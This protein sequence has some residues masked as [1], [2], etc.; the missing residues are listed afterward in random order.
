MKSLHKSIKATSYIAG[1][2]AIAA[3]MLLVVFLVMSILG[4]IH[5]RKERITLQTKTITKIYDATPLE[6]SEPIISYG[7]L[8]EGHSIAIR[9]IPEYTIVGV[10]DNAPEFVILDESGAD[11]SAQYDINYDYGKLIIQ[12]RKITLSC[13]K[14]SKVYDGMPITCNEA[15]LSGGS[16]VPGDVIV[17]EGGNT[18]LL[19]GEVK[20]QPAYR[21]V[22]ESGADVTNQYKITENFGNLEIL[23]I[24]LY[25]TT[26]SAEK[27]YD[28]MPLV[29]EEWTITGGS[30]EN[31]QVLKAQQY[32]T[33]QNVGS[34]DNVINFLVLDEAGED[35]T[36]R[37]SII[38]NYGTLHIKPKAI[39]IR[40]GSDQKVYI[41]QP[42]RG[43]GNR[44]QAAVD[45]S[46]VT[47]ACLGCCSR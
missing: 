24:P 45:K 20:S 7:S 30:L 9:K 40:T 19:P 39:T 26:G 4:L 25:V 41:R 42:C 10:Y 21:I 46:K 5:P 11:V 33:Q 8:H 17:T 3:A 35:I 32:S 36:N 34:T 31:G 1:I 22:S 27:V 12:T 47:S 38:C 29:C 14:K 43:M 2:F 44:K 18:L 13:S 15:Y 28:G 23:P 37:Y 6:G 16:F